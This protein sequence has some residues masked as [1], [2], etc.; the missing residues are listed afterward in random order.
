MTVGY[1]GEMTPGRR[2]PVLRPYQ[3]LRVSPGWLIAV[4]LAA[5][6]GGHI[7]WMVLRLG[8]LALPYGLTDGVILAALLARRITAAVH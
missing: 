8:G 4:L 6:V 7:L 1:G 5:L 2:D 3:P